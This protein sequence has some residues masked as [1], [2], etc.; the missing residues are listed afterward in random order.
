MAIDGK[1]VDFVYGR[2]EQFSSVSSIFRRI[3]I[4]GGI[5]VTIDRIL[6][7][8]EARYFKNTPR[9]VVGLTSAVVTD[10]VKTGM[11]VG[12]PLLSY[13]TLIK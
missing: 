4:P 13:Y 9:R 6:Q 3:L 1:L 10:V 12:I 2:D 11:Y 8:E 7:S 5:I